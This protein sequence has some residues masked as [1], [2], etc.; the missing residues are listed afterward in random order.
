MRG[1]SARRKAYEGYD[2]FLLAGLC[3]KADLFARACLAADAVAL[4]GGIAPRALQVADYLLG[5]VRTFSLV[6]S[7]MTCRTLCGSRSYATL[8]SGFSIRCTT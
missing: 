6:L 1:L 4:D 2:V 3:L 8:P 5:I 7:L